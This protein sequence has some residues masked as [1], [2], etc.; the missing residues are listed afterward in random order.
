M[1]LIQA[2]ITSNNFEHSICNLLFEVTNKKKQVA[3]SNIKYLFVF[4]DLPKLLICG[5]L[6]LDLEE[7][8]TCEVI[9]LQSSSTTCQNLPN[10][11]V[12][13]AIGGL[14][15]K[16]NPIICGGFQSGTIPNSCSSL[17]NNE[18]VYSYS[19]NEARRFAAATQLQDG[20]LLVTGGVTGALPGISLDSV[21]I[22]TE[23]GWQSTTPSLPVT[24][25]GHCMV[26]INS[27]TV[28]VI[29]GWQNSDLSGKTFY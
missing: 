27:T 2:I 6:M 3:T 18:W 25:A 4:K 11:P 23:D 28:I 7:V 22:L 13:V 1:K 10:F 9:D 12:F 14:G 16:E 15:L 21:E 19:M 20:K 29:G 5:G 8:V 26:T 17:E 24:I